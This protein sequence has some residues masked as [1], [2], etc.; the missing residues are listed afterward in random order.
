[1]RSTTVARALVDCGNKVMTDRLLEA[2]KHAKAE[3]LLTGREYAQVRRALTRHEQ[4]A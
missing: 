4:V 1:M 2:A 3:G